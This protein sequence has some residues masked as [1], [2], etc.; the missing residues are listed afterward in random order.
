MNIPKNPFKNLILTP[1]EQ[2]VEDNL[3]NWKS[4]PNLEEEKKRYAQMAKNTLEQMNYPA[5]S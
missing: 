1:E 5:A 4:I 3:E 2:E